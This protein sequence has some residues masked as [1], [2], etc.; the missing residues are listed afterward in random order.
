MLPGLA[1]NSWA[2]AIHL[3]LSLPKCWDYRCEPWHLVDRL[4]SKFTQKLVSL[5]TLCKKSYGKNTN[6]QEIKEMKVGRL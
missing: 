2:R 1:L 5:I 3:P 4:F 6:N